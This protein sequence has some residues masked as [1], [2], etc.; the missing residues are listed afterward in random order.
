MKLTNT[1]YVQNGVEWRAWLEQNHQ[2]VRELWLIFYK[3]GTGIPSIS[4]DDALDEALCFGWIDS[5]IQRI[6]DEKYAR[7]F[8]PR[9]NTNKWSEVNKKKIARL[10]RENR[11]TEA[12]LRKIPDLSGFDESAPTPKRSAMVIPPEIEKAIQANPQAWENYSRLAPSQR[13]NYIGW[14]LSAKKAETVDKRLKEII[15]DL[16]QNKPLGQK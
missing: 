13:R 4:Y 8:T 2:S 6:D 1:L 7:K 16:A 11:M 14:V 15:D 9:T 5:I 3:A 12:G 10:I